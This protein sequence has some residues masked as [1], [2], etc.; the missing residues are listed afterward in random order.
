MHGRSTLVHILDEP[1]IRLK[2]MR[3]CVDCRKSRET[4]HSEMRQLF[5]YVCCKKFLNYL[6]LI[7]FPMTCI[8]II[9]NEIF[10]I[11]KPKQLNRLTNP[12]S[13]P[14]PGQGSPKKS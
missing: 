3:V 6:N 9:E 14:P 5:N 7:S 13:G 10:K 11:V 8:L 2:W 1:I 4:K 12:A